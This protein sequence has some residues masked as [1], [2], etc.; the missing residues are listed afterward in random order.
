MVVTKKLQDSQIDSTW[1]SISTGRAVAVA[2]HA[3]VHLSAE[4]AHLGAFVVGG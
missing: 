3:T 4:L 1:Q 2:E